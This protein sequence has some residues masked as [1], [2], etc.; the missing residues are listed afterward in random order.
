MVRSYTTDSQSIRSVL[1]A[2]W[3]QFV[4]L[5]HRKRNIAVDVA[6]SLQHHDWFFK[7]AEEMTGLRLT[8]TRALEIGHGQM[9]FAAA[10]LSSLGNEV[11]GVDLDVLPAGLWDVCK[12][13]ALLRTN[14]MSR[15]IKTAGRQLMGINVALQREFVRQLHVPHWPK[16]FL[17][18]GSATS[19]PYADESFDFVYSF[20]VLE[21][22]D[23]PP[24]AIAEAVRVLRPGGAAFFMFPHYA[25]VNALHDM[26]WITHSP[27][28]PAPWA[29]LIPP[30]R[31]L[32]EQGA[33]VNAY[34]LHDWRN[35]FE[36]ACPGVRFDTTAIQGQKI[37]D[38]LK[39]HRSHG[40]LAD[41]SDDELLTDDLIAAWRKPAA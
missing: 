10:F 33:Y 13:W 3:R 37:H 11:H 34:R 12:Y 39:H 25:H 41:F 8:G 19:L 6:G 38:A 35:A 26:R 4:A 5:R 40:W 24:A 28:S 31:P 14:G 20:H 21:H 36:R 2:G 30:L 22:I 27:G 1:Y 7:R 18:Q 16:L 17:Q 29:H 9:P 15:A 23:D 32:V